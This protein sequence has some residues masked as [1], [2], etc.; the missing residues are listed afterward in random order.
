MQFLK[1]NN[2]WYKGVEIDTNWEENVTDLQKGSENDTHLNNDDHQQIATDTCLQP[3]DIAQEVLDQYF[4]DIYNIALG[5]GNNPVR[6]LQE[7][8]NEAK[9][10]PHLSPSGRFSWNEVRDTRITLS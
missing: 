6:L 10:F 7:Q 3:V 4:D 9:A 8:G 1:E 5:E 2:E